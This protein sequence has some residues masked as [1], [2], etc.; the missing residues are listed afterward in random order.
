MIIEKSNLREL[1]QDLIDTDD[2]IRPKLKEL[3]AT[4]HPYQELEPLFENQVALLTDIQDMKKNPDVDRSEVYH[5]Q[6][7][8]ARYEDAIVALSAKLAFPS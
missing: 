6:A 5:F 2:D 4:K 1:F 7:K 3:I 8:H